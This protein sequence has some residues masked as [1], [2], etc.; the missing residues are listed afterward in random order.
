LVSSVNRGGSQLQ[1]SLVLLG[2]SPC[3]GGFGQAGLFVWTKLSFRPANFLC[4]CGFIGKCLYTKTL[5]VPI[6]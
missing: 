6:C 1:G 5:Y 4:V 2:R 3:Q